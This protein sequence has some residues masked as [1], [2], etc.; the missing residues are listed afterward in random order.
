MAKQK[1]DKKAP[2]NQFAIY[3]I[4]IKEAQQTLAFPSMSPQTAIENACDIFESFF[5]GCKLNLYRQI[6]K[7]GEEEPEIFPNDILSVHDGVYLLRINNNKKKK[8]VE[9]AETTTNG[10]VDYEENTYISNPYCYVVIDNRAEK[11]ICQMAIQKNSAWGDPNNVRKLLQENFNRQF[12]NDS[13]PLELTLSAKQ[14]PSQ[15]WEFCKQRCNEGQDSIQRIS[16]DFPN[17]KKIGTLHRIQNPKGYV[18]RLA[19]IMELTDAIKT[20]ISMEYTDANPNKIEKHA[21]DLANIV[22][23]CHNKSYNLSILFRSYGL[24]KCDDRVRA[25]FPME[26]KLLNSFREKWEELELSGEKYGL[27]D[28]CNFVYEQSKLYDYVEATPTQRSRKH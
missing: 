24:Y 11:G 4:V 8:V 26:E 2:I 7:N 5:R 19:Q 12:C 28:W 21:N 15:I 10:V 16:F 1:Q 22:R 25:M 17:Q 23:L 6:K 20:H 9:P 14:R 18:K 27:F 13:I 3:E